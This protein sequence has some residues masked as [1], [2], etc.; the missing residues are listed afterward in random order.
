[1]KTFSDMGRNFVG[2]PPAKLGIRVAFIANW[3][4][5]N[6]PLWGKLL[7]GPGKSKTSGEDKLRTSG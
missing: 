4:K 2:L 7:G 6:N 1:M 3:A 5:I